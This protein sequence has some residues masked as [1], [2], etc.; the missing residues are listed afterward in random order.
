MS[1]VCN[2]CVADAA[3]SLLILEEGE[4][5][6]CDYCGQ[7][8][9]MHGVRTLSI[10]DLADQIEERIFWQYSDVD[11]EMISYDSE[12]DEYMCQTFTTAELLR[13]EIGLDAP[14]AVLS[15]LDAELPDLTW[16]KKRFG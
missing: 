9:D 16:C 13:D 4:T 5:R 7:T 1:F 10:H 2:H 14:D 11:S 8:P 15:D 6:T 3:L 12:D